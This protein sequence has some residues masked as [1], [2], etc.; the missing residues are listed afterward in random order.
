[1][2]HLETR[3]H[4]GGESNGCLFLLEDEVECRPTSSW[5]EL[6]APGGYL[7]KLSRALSNRGLNLIYL[8]LSGANKAWLDVFSSR[9]GRRA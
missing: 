2:G 6:H 9:T 8:I 4:Q 3:F 7:R 1:M 5:P